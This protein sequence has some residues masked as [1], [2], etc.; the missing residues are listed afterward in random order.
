MPTSSMPVLLAV[1]RVSVLFSGALV[2]VLLSVTLVSSVL[3]TV[4]GRKKVTLASSAAEAPFPS[5]TIRVAEKRRLHLMLGDETPILILFQ[6]A[7]SWIYIISH[8]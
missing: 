6:V 8:V 4:L 1:I 2:P 5:K 7:L 3:F